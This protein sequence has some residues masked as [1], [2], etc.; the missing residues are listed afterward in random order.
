[1]RLRDY[2]VPRGRLPEIAD[3][4]AERPAAKA[5]PRPASA[6]EILTLLE[7]AW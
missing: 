6:A 7:E 3:K 2:D 1:M 5:N 4:T